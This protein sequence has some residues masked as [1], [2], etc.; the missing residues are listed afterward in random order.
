LVFFIF[1]GAPPP[2]RSPKPAPEKKKNRNQQQAVERSAP[3]RA[4]AERHKIALFMSLHNAMQRR[5]RG[6]PPLP[7]DPVVP[8]LDDELR[9]MLSRETIE[10]AEGRPSTSG[11]A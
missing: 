5:Q 6:E 10:A 2:M 11:R 1:V 7:T 8:P 9:A 3:R 4:E